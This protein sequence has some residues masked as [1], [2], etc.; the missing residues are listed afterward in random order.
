MKFNQCKVLLIAN[1][2]FGPR[3]SA[4]FD[5]STQVT[6]ASASDPRGRCT[7]GL[8]IQ[9]DKWQGL[10]SQSGLNS[11][12]K[13]IGEEEKTICMVAG[14][15]DPC[16][17]YQ[18]GFISGSF[19]KDE[20]FLHLCLCIILCKWR[21]DCGSQRSTNNPEQV[22]LLLALGLFKRHRPRVFREYRE[23][24]VSKNTYSN[25]NS[26]AQLMLW[27]GN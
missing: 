16:C 24:R 1:R 22:P 7:A 12:H 10:Q 6:E 23:R 5:P 2:A 18:D 15:L 19:W 8:A 11:H 21:A 13:S 20:T 14:L 9:G 27:M 25:T 4:N 17:F 3:I 26:S